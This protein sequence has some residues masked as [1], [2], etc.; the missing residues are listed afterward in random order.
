MTETVTVEL[1]EATSE[2]LRAALRAAAVHRA[3]CE[4]Q[5]NYMHTWSER[6]AAIQSELDRR[7]AA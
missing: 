3:D 6:M 1:R 5:G 4:N 2:Q 7:R